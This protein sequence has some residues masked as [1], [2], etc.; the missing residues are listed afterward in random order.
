MPT[1][2]IQ[3]LGIK[4]LIPWVRAPQTDALLW[5]A[6]YPTISTVPRK[7]T[8]CVQENLKTPLCAP[9]VLAAYLQTCPSKKG[10]QTPVRERWELRRG[11]VL[12]YQFHL[13][14]TV[15]GGFYRSLSRSPGSNHKGRVTFSVQRGSFQ[16]FQQVPV[17]TAATG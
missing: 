12:Y 10:K 11:A 17:L 16:Q 4:K 8:L 14:S 15:N 9:R 1:F 5:P 7:A 13:A 2:A 3:I 6:P